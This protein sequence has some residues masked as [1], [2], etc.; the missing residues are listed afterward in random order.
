[1]G[2]VPDI[3]VEV[4]FESAPLDT[5]PTYTDVTG[6]VDSFRLQRGRSYELDEV[7][8]GTGS[9][10]FDNADGRFTPGRTAITRHMISPT[11]LCGRAEPQKTFPGSYYSSAINGVAGGSVLDIQTPSKPG[12]IAWIPGGAAGRPDVKVIPLPTNLATVTPGTQYT[13]QCK[14]RR[15]DSTPQGAGKTFAYR[16]V[17]DYYDA[18]GVFLTALLLNKTISNVESTISATANAVTNARYLGWRLEA[19]TVWTASDTDYIEIRDVTIYE[20]SG[21]STVETVSPYWP[22]IRPRRATRFSVNSEWV[23]HGFVEKWPA[24]F[25][26]LLGTTDVSLVDGYGIL[27]STKLPAPVQAFTRFQ[28][29][30]HYYPL[31]EGTEATEAVDATAAGR[32]G[33]IKL[34]DFGGA[35]SLGASAV[36]LYG[37]NGGAAFEVTTAD[38]DGAGAV[39]ELKS[40]TD[41]Q[42][43]DLSKFAVSFYYAGPWPT[44][45]ETNTLFYIEGYD[46]DGTDA[47]DTSKLKIEVTSTGAITF[48]GGRLSRSGGIGR[49]TSITSAA[50][51]I[52][53][54]EPVHIMFHRVNDG[55]IDDV[56][57]LYVN[58]VE[59][60]RDSMMDPTA[61]VQA[62]LKVGTVQV[63][64]I[65]TAILRK[66]MNLG[67]YSHVA[68][69]GSAQNPS[70]VAAGL[71]VAQK[72]TAKGLNVGASIDRTETTRLNEILDYAGWPTGWRDIGG[73]GD[74]APVSTLDPADWESGA[75]ALEAFQKAAK[76]AGGVVMVDRFGWMTYLN[77]RARLNI[78]PQL[79]IGPDWEIDFEPGLFFEADED[80][81][82][83]EVIGKRA[84]GGQTTATDQ[85]SINEYG[86]RTVTLE[87][88]VATDVE[89]AD[90][91]NWFLY[92]YKDA[93]IRCDQLV[94]S[95]T[96]NSTDPVLAY[97][98]TATAEVGYKVK[99]WDLPDAGPFTEAEFFLEGIQ[100][101]VSINGETPE[102]KTTLQLSPA[103]NSNAAV[104]DDNA[105]GLL[106]DTAI[107]TY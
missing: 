74:S 28:N 3:K 33:R 73:T 86:R 1:M 57:I 50:G 2:Y 88:G 54:N 8:A 93:I 58:G 41:P 95:P 51:K 75:S 14:I 76:D 26:T 91:A 43:F 70:T 15:N 22:N 29:P 36:P 100:H 69:W 64:G 39:L 10:A 99:V 106:D 67:R 13:I 42:T 20:G 89:A 84:L 77:R 85:A 72:M 48:W 16:L 21:I 90:A 92:R 97:Y 101:D 79:D 45:G 6:Y 105:F 62:L 5:T 78:T 56:G 30:L 27:A 32:N 63:G 59:V 12:M 83:N 66:N 31:N 24:R 98:S 37:D 68:L 61:I 96:V 23:F 71:A 104:L 38:G 87:L 107:L 55:G 25:D 60:G 80:R 47:R 7:E 35:A 17:L 11:Y 40:K 81:I 34:S 9:I 65:N 102:W 18:A 82:A 44:A 19:Q 103:T 4:A 94:I 52:P 46:T 49:D 53:N